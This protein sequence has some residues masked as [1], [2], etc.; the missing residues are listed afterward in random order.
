MLRPYVVPATLE[1][2]DGPPTG[3]IELP[4]HLDW[5]PERLY[6][7]DQISDVRLLYTRVIRESATPDDLRRHLNAT[8]LRE[9]W[10][11][12]VLPP[13]VRTLWL[14]RFPELRVGPAT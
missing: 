4:R 10:P 7:L 2:L 8:I 12:L 1:E 13:R 11:D 3:T 14:E 9:V 6:H 5:G